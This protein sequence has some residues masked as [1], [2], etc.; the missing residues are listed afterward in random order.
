MKIRAHHLL[1]MQGFQ[2]YGY[3]KKFVKNMAA[4]IAELAANPDTEIEI[5]CEGDVICSQCPFDKNNRCA[6]WADAH[7]HMRNRDVAI[8]DT[9][10][11]MPNTRM[12]IKEVHNLIEKKINTPEITQKLCGTCLWKKKCLW[13]IKQ[14]KNTKKKFSL[15][16]IFGM[17]IF[18]VVRLKPK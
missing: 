6:M 7:E 3:S 1:C 13:F 12:K 4:V 14:T 17:L 11:L 18:W 5:V 2:G 9:L 8:L 16:R 15:S 10:G